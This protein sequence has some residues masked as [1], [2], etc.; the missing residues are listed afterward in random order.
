MF[1]DLD[2]FNNQ[3]IESQ[4]YDGCQGKF[5]KSVLYHLFYFPRV[6]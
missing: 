4:T 3:E 6:T 5:E 2:G 1:D